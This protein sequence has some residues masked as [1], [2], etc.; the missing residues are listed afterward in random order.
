M[1]LEF[2]SKAQQD[3]I[4]S[5]WGTL[6]DHCVNSLVG[7][8]WYWKLRLFPLKFQIFFGVLVLFFLK[9]LWAACQ[10]TL[11]DYTVM[12]S[13]SSSWCYLPQ[14]RHVCISGHM[15]KSTRRAAVTQQLKLPFVFLTNHLKLLV[16]RKNSNYLNSLLQSKKFLHIHVHI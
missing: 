2:W 6:G 16:F 1:R 5:R 12:T 9:E 4:G 14:A 7:V 3:R 10:F 11:W 15:F 13:L 8:I